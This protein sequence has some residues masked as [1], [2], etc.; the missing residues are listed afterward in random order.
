MIWRAVAAAPKN[1]LARPVSLASRFQSTQAPPAAASSLYA[2]LH[3][4]GIADTL[5]AKKAASIQTIVANTEDKSLFF[6]NNNF[7][8]KFGP[9]AYCLVTKGRRRKYN[10][11]SRGNW[12][13]MHRTQW[14][15]VGIYAE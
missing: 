9:G 15:K 13:T 5:A 6:N 14:R 12:G 10:R 8:L 3:S 1:V 7:R 2:Q 11:G 4:E